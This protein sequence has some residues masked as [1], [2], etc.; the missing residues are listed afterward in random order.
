MDME[1]TNGPTQV[2]TKETGKT[3][4]S[5]DMVTTPG[6]TAEPFRGTGSIIICMAKESTNGPMEDSIS[7]TGCAESNMAS[8]YTKPSTPISSTASGKRVNV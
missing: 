4:K 5:Q 6:T 7:V 8:E 1:C 2:F 3:T